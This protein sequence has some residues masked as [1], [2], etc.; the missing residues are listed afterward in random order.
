MDIT[1]KNGDRLQTVQEH[2]GL[3]TRIEQVAWEFR[4]FCLKNVGMGSLTPRIGVCSGSRKKMEFFND[5]AG[6]L[7]H[8]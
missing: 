8:G 6:V 4:E 5:K 7:G 2:R 1:D 3:A